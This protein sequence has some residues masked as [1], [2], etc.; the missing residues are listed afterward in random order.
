M[1]LQ[2]KAYQQNDDKILGWA[3]YPKRILYED[4]TTWT[5]QEHGECFQVFWR[6]REHPDIKV[7]PPSIAYTRESD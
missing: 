5:P 1:T 6:D 4:G 2:M 3:V 7:L